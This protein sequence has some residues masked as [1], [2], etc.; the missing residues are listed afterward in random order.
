VHEHM[1]DRPDECPEMQSSPIRLTSAVRKA[2]PRT[3]LPACTPPARDVGS[4]LE[5]TGPAPLTL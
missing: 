5:C 2:T 3:R 4:G 1:A